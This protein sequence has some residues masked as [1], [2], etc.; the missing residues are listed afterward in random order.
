MTPLDMAEASTSRDDVKQA[1]S[2]AL[3]KV[4]LEMR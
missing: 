3:M 1:L 2:A 4:E